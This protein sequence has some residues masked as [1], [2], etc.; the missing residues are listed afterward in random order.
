MEP[1]KIIPCLDMKDGRV[2]KGVNF[3]ELR[4]AGDPV[5]NARFYQQAGADELAML[6][7]AATTEGR[8]T[9]IDWARRVAEAIDMPLTVGGGISTVDDIAELLDVGVARISINSAAVRRP[10][11]IGEAAAAFGPERL[12]VAIDGRA[13]PD[14]ASGFEVMVAGGTRGTG[15]DVARWAH[16][17]EELGAG[18]ILPTSMGGDG[19]LDGYDIQFTKAVTGAVTVP[20]IASGGAGK[21]EHFSEV[22][23][24]AGVQA[25]LA[26][27]VFHFR[28][29]TIDQVKD[30]L[31]S[32]G[33]PVNR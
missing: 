14:M 33:I 1:V 9:R 12:T 2:V 28:T 17:C 22:V 11:L 3:V 15:M 4:D 30:Q 26:A 32:R 6:D 23:E 27:S 7:I 21:L 29:F 8:G 20:V 31:E 25:V 19:T 16:R 13:N 24:R 10:E 5:D 18:T